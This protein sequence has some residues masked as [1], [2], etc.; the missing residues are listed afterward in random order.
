[1]HIDPFEQFELWYGEEV[2]SKSF[3]PDSV[4]ISTTGINMMPSS[5]VVF[6]RKFSRKGFTFFTNY[7]S[8][9]GRQIEEN[10]KASM[11]FFWPRL[12]RQVRIEGIIGKTTSEE[13]DEYFDSRP[14]LNKA[15]SIISMQS[16]PLKDKQ[17]FDKDVLVLAGGGVVLRRPEHW[18]GYTL[19]PL[20]FEFWQDGANR[21]H[22]RFQ[23]TPLDEGW[24]ITRLYP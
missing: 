3:L 23:Y 7:N 4:V 5:R 20:L 2:T 22:D 13:S 11:L 17:R 1:M 9:K 18:G 19:R 15:S 10:D 16:S 21:C 6:M 8:R 14:D 24:E 12:M